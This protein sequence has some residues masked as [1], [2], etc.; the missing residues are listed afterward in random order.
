MRVFG[1][2]SGM[3]VNGGFSSIEPTMIDVDE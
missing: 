1:A 2:H 3:V